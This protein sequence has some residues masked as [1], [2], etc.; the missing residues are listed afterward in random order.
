MTHRQKIKEY[1]S[2]LVLKNKSVVDWGSGSK[3]AFRYI[4]SEGCTFTTIDNAPGIPIDRRGETHHNN[5]ISEFFVPSMEGYDVAFCLEV[6]EHVKSPEVLLQ[7][8]YRSLKP[9]GTLYL[10]APFLYPKHGNSDYW[11]FTDQG[12]KEIL[13]THKFKVQLI[14]D[15]VDDLG[16]IV[17]AIK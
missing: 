6:L 7:N 12:I 4:Q 14:L 3:P 15:T 5:D 16:W 1:L 9:G 10:S 2:A 8:I 13:E 17:K 11:R